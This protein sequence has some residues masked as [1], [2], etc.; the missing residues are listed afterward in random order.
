MC[1]SNLLCRRFF[2]TFVAAWL[3]AGSAVAGAPPNRI[4][5]DLE[6]GRTFQL[7][8]NTRPRIASLPDTGAMAGQ[9]TLPHIA[10]DFKM[11][12][13][14]QAELAKL[15]AE[16]QDPSSP[17]YQN[18]LTPE[19]YGERFGMN[20]SDLKKVQHWLENLGFRDIQVSRSRNSISMSGTAS[21]AQYAFQTAIHR[22][23][24]NGTTHYANTS[25]P[26]LPAAMRGTVASVRGLS[27]LHPKPHARAVARPRF[28]SSISNN[29]FMAPGDFATIYD[30]QTLYTNGIDGTGRKIA[31]AG[32]TD[33]QIFDIEAFQT[34][35][36]LTVKDPTVIVDGADPGL[37]KDDL[38]EA[39]LDVEWAGAVARGATIVYVNSPDVFNSA[40]Y[41]IN[42]K[43]ADALSLTYGVCEA[44]VGT[45][46]INTLN[47]VFQQ[48][49][50][51]G[52]TIVAASGDSG[53]ADCDSSTDPNKPITSA[54]QGLAVDFPASSPYVTGMGGTA[55]NE[56]TGSY[57]NPTNNANGG[58]AISYIPEQAWNDTSSTEGLSATG[59][60]ASI[61][62]TKP[63]WQTGP[64]VPA[65]GQRDV[66]DISLAVS[67]AHDG[68]L[69]CSTPP[70][71]TGVPATT[72]S[73]VNGFRNSDQTLNVIGGTS[74]AAPTFAGIVALID[75]RT[76]ISQGNIN[77]RLYAL[78]ALVPEAF[79]DITT[80][81]NQVP[82]TAGT[83]GCAT[84]TIGY[85]AAV[86]Y[87]QVTGLGT[88][89]A[90]NLVDSWAPSFT[91]AVSPSTLTVADASSGAA[92]VTVSPAG[93]FT[94]IVSF[95]CA[96]PSTLT[97]TT[98]SIPATVTSSGSTTLTITNA[99][100]VSSGISKPR[101]SVP[102]G[103]TLPL[104]LAGFVLLVSAGALTA[105]KRSPR[106]RF[107]SAAAVVSALL[108]VACGGGS[109]P[110]SS[111]T[112]TASVTG[113]VTITAV[114]A[115]TA[116]TGS[117]TETVTLPVTEH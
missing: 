56:G 13:A 80:G 27:D 34:A 8:G 99:T 2:P 28:T 3:L 114:S 78:A 63:S 59:G 93:G 85:S 75:Q 21:L 10:I 40:I 115:P 52:M 42:N 38:S 83:T 95:S 20:P 97:N 47:A 94:G 37:Q 44:Q 25:D 73:C 62:F 69:I 26:I 86:G 64:G 92:T 89:D 1:N 84:G 49:N 15:L 98:C 74:V 91:L 96:V 81:T 102:T 90:N 116:L 117:I 36:G 106:V 48:A 35:A 60:G 108:T 104:S 55:F 14:Q 19:Q 30:V 66:P 76:G 71:S 70:S 82:C 53:A 109:S 100:A 46:E 88:V 33:I 22:F 79:H 57:W 43:V 45:S 110:N 101:W 113:T 67:P 17:Q 6:N 111:A 16:Q 112:Q 29:H 51:E 24:L 68:Y 107:A 9:E 103:G 11:S 23:E 58:S 50:A 4:R 72:S 12:D 41:A 61:T 54:T 87:D 31:I 18:W 105:I 65:D 77:P 7:Q 5:E 39:E 32:Q